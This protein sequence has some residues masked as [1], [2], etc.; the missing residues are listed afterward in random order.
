MFVILSHGQ[1]HVLAHIDMKCT[2]K[3]GKN[4]RGLVSLGGYV[5]GEKEQRT[6][7]NIGDEGAMRDMLQGCDES[8]MSL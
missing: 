5:F 3:H 8:P 6:T 1:I 2:P 7:K 4:T